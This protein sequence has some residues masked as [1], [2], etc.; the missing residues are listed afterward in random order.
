MSQPTITEYKN[1]VIELFST[2][3]PSPECYAEMASAVLYASEADAEETRAIDMALGY[4]FLSEDT[5]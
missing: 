5:E 2:G 1:Q 3:K 4:D